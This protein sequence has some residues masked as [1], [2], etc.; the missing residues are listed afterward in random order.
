[1]DFENKKIVKKRVDVVFLT[2][3]SQYGQL[4]NIIANT[5]QSVRRRRCHAFFQL[6]NFFEEG[7]WFYVIFVGKRTVKKKFDVAWI[8]VACNWYYRGGITKLLALRNLFRSVAAA[9]IIIIVIIITW[10]VL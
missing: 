4:I 10:F 1:M 6:C 8:L 9:C 2:L 7:C 3:C 5:V